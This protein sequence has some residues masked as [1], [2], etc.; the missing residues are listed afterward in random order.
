MRKT[1]IRDGVVENVIGINTAILAGMPVPNP[2]SW[3]PKGSLFPI[4][5]TYTDLAMIG[6]ALLATKDAF[7]QVYL[8][9]KALIMSETDAAA[10]AAYDVTAGWPD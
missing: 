5:V 2:R 7:M 3:T 6:G 1:L 8:T 4:Q 9:H 10:V